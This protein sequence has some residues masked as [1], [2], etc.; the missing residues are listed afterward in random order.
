[1]PCFFDSDKNNVTRVG[2]LYQAGLRLLT[3]YTQ[4][5]ISDPKTGT[6]INFLNWY[7]ASGLYFQTGA[8]ER[9]NA[10]S[11]G[12]FWASARWIACYTPAANLKEFLPYVETDGFYHGF[13][14]GL[15]VEINNLV[16]MRVLYYKYQKAPELDY[17]QSIYQFTFNYSLR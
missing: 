3:G 4:G 11:T 14:I 13:C 9:N 6:P 5:L 7:A 1:M 8:W 15:G 17:G 12:I 2:I 16:N 10:A